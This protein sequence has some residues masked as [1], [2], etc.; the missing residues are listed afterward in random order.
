MI[1]SGS[2]IIIPPHYLIAVEELKP[3]LEELRDALLNRP[4]P[5]GTPWPD[6]GAA[7]QSI[8]DF[9]RVFRTFESPVLDLDE[10]LAKNEVTTGEMKS[11]IHKVRKVVN[12]LAE[13]YHAIWRRSYPYGME[14]GQL[15]AG[16]MTER[17]L[18]TIYAGFEE[19][20]QAAEH[21]AHAPQNSN[22]LRVAI[23][24]DFSFNPEAHEFERFCEELVQQSNFVAVQSV[25]RSSRPFIWSLIAAFCFGWWFGDD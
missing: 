17:I 1:M 16:S 12:D 19:L 14:R 13:A 24:M 20:V 8:E 6:L 9:N 5:G 10:L 23:N 4:F 22:S 18:K 2:T 15:L 11:A 3:M 7:M 21:P 25:V